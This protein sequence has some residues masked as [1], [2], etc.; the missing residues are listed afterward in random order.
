MLSKMQSNLNPFRSKV[1]GVE[2]CGLAPVLK[3]FDAAVDVVD[4]GM[5]KRPAAMT[6]YVEPWH[7]DVLSF[8]RMKRISGGDANHTERLFYALWTNDILYVPLI[9]NPSHHLN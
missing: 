9:P 1:D 5:N 3:M 6:V 2:S 7:A 8:V 4:Q